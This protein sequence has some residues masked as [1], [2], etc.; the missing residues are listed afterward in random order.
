MAW[1]RARLKAVSATV[2]PG[3]EG[4]TPGNPTSFSVSFLGSEH[5]QVPVRAAV[6]LKPSP[7]TTEFHSDANEGA[8]CPPPGVWM[9]SFAGGF[10]EREM[11]DGLSG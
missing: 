6:I 2:F 9:R 3:P 1:I 10:L 8:E 11:T 7:R 4:E 5:P